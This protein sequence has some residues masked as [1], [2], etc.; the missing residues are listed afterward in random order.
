MSKNNFIV[1]GIIGVLIVALVG[2]AFGLESGTEQFSSKEILKVNNEVYKKEEFVD[3]IKY[4]I[5]TNDGDIT[6]DEEAYADQLAAGTSEEDIFVSDSLERFYQMKVYGILAKEKNIS[7][8][9]EELESI[10]TD[11]NSN[12]DKIIAAGLNE[13]KYI[14]IAKQQ[15]IIDKITNN[16]TEYLELP[17]GVYD[18]FIGQFSGDDL[19][20][21]TYRLIQVGYTAD[22]VSGEV[23]GE[24]SGEIV[25]GD[26]A[27]KEEY[28]NTLVARINS[29]EAFET[30]AESGDNRLVFVGNGIQFAKSLQEYSAGF[31]LEQKLY[32]EKLCNAVKNAEVGKITEVVDTG[33]SFQIALVEKKE[34]GI[35]GQAKDE[36]IQLMISEYSSQIIY[37]VVD[38]ME[39]NNSAVARIDIKR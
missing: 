1:L 37:S 36:V 12:K 34:D 19:K 16:A 21:Y 25:P 32:D 39:V 9:G 31:L 29:G 13:D 7:L 18:E 28:M 30:V 2:L 35:V 24:S 26:R 8:S 3:F 10:T 11:F 27:E 33:D 22:K 23:S 17:D 14:E 38:S 4:L 6:I 15:A 5:Y 20:S